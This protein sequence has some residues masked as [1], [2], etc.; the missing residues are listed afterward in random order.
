MPLPLSSSSISLARTHSSHRS[1]LLIPPRYSVTQGDFFRVR[2]RSKEVPS[3]YC[4]AVPSTPCICFSPPPVTSNPITFVG[5][6][7]IQFNQSDPCTV[8]LSQ[9][10][11]VSSF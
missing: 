10:E 8:F 3:S 2:D 11:E 1:S 6:D 4:F 5:V 9:S 7:V